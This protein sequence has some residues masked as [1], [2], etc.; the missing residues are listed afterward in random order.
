M[1]G[2]NFSLPDNPTAE[3]LEALEGEFVQVAR[4]QIKY[5]PSSVNDYVK[6]RVRSSVLVQER[7]EARVKNEDYLPSACVRRLLILL[8]PRWRCSQKSSSAH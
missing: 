6:W 7:P 4:A 1:W 8:S 2:A 5:G 3:K